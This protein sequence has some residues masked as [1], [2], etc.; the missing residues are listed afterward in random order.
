MWPGLVLG[1]D[2]EQAHV[3][4][5]SQEH[6]CLMSRKHA[7]GSRRDWRWRRRLRL[8][9]SETL[10]EVRR[11]WTARRAAA[12]VCV[13]V[14]SR[15]RT[16]RRAAAR[17]SAAGPGIPRRRGRVRDKRRCA[18]GVC[19]CGQRAAWWAVSVAELNQSSHISHTSGI[20]DPGFRL[21]TFELAV[22][23]SPSCGLGYQLV[24]DVCVCNSSHLPRLCVI[25]CSS[26][27]HN[28][29]LHRL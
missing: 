4:M 24:N 22:L 8:H 20:H 17:P 25:S 5:E 26:L 2:P 21:C 10:Q 28:W 14:G 15:S 1:R 6:P 18:A 23:N 11:R 3:T 27:E 13:A 12:S 29:L 19:V 16:R 7:T 9:R